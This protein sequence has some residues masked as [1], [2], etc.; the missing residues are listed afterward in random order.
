VSNWL[1]SIWKEL[2]VL[3][4][5][6]QKNVEHQREWM[7]VAIDD[8]NAAFNLEGSGFELD[9]GKIGMSLLPWK[10]CPQ[11]SVLLL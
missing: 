10:R 9:F 5:E 1:R 11:C 8:I 3:L 6:S 2:Q 4:V 7:V